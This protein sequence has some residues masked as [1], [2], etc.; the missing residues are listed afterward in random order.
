LETF[1]SGVA[2]KKSKISFF[3][4]LQPRMLAGS[5]F[6]FCYGQQHHAIGNY[7]RESIFL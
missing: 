5:F 7:G 3:Y 6:S 4:E 1:S 2:I